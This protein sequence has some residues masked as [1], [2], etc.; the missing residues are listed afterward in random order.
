MLIREQGEAAAGLWRRRLQ[1]LALFGAE[2]LAVALAV[3]VF[4]TLVERGLVSMALGLAML[5]LMAFFL[6]AGLLQRLALGRYDALL[7]TFSVLPI[8]IALMALG[9]PLRPQAPPVYFVLTAGASIVAAGLVG[10]FM[11]KRQEE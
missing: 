9:E 2:L 5:A 6:H 1:A 3:R 7:G 11:L 8:G 4:R 10:A